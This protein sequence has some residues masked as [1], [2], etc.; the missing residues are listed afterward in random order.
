MDCDEDIPPAEIG[1][2]HIAA[3]LELADAMS[4]TQ[5]DEPLSEKLSP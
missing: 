2:E 3:G 1:G 5:Y 4:S